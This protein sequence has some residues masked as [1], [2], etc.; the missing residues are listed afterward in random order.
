MRGDGRCP[1][2][3]PPGEAPAPSAGPRGCAGSPGAVPGRPCCRLLRRGARDACALG[4]PC[5]VIGVG[6]DL[7]DCGHAAR[8]IRAALVSGRLVVLIPAVPAPGAQAELLRPHQPRLFPEHS[9]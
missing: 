2:Q 8:E 6:A 1:A 5:E 4:S 7:L 9:S 3:L